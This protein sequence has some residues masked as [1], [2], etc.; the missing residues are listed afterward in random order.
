MKELKCKNCGGRVDPNT[1]RCEYCGTQYAR[2]RSN[3]LRVETFPA[4]VDVLCSEVVF[5]EYMFLCDDPEP[6]TE[7]AVKSLCHSFTERLLPYMEIKDMHDPATLER[8]LKAYLRV[9]RPG[10]KF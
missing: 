2:D 6:V 9:A 3:V 8:H 5:P 10:A 7:Y 4:K 1:L